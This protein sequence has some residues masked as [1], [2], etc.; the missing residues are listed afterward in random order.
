MGSGKGGDR[1]RHLGEKVVTA[2]HEYMSQAP[3]AVVPRILEVV[4]LP[5]TDK[6][7]GGIQGLR[8]REKL[9]RLLQHFLGET[10]LVYV[11]YGDRCDPG[12][13]GIP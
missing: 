11:Q 9:R 10:V 4:R 3:L 13:S 12:G 6:I 1:D 5:R 7:H 8:P 2:A